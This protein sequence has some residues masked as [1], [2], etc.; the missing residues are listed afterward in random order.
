MSKRK[1]LSTATIIR[2]AFRVGRFLPFW[3]APYLAAIWASVIPVVKPP[4]YRGARANLRHVLGEGASQ[5]DLDRTLHQLFLNAGRRYY[6]TFCNLGRGIT[7]AEDFHPSVIV[8]PETQAHIKQALAT[9]KGLLILACHTSNFDLGGIA[10][11]QW[12]PEPLQVLSLADPTRDVEVFNHLRQQ[13]GVMMT[14]ITPE[15]LRDAMK[16]LRAGGV[17]VTGP[18]YPTDEDS[19]PVI[20][21]GAPANLPTGYVRIPLRTGSQVMVVAIWHRDGTYRIEGNPP[22]AL[23]RTGDRDQDVMVNLRRILDE[24]EAFIRERPEEWM[25]FTPVW[26]DDV[27]T[28]QQ[29]IST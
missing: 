18:D 11:A 22:M 26:K 23:V 10:L 14:P 28:I 6:E 15:T 9:R 24:V 4:M 16:R 20:F 3:G 7:R 2:L 27:K 17:V 29:A 1:L 5:R 25:M 13:S 8:T 19:P 12:M 21:F